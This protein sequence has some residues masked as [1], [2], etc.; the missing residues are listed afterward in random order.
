MVKG[1][2]GDNSLGA[3]GL[4]KQGRKEVCTKIRGRKVGRNGATWH[5]EVE[6]AMGGK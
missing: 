4:G 3:G 2:S 6:V 5:G 1:C